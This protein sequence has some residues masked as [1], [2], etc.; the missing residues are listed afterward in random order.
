MRSLFLALALS[1]PATGL[2]AKVS[3][4]TPPAP[5]EGP[6][7]AR[8]ASS[9]S[10]YADMVPLPPVTGGD[11][12]LD[13]ERLARVITTFN[14]TVDASVI[15]EVDAEE[16]LGLRQHLAADPRWRVTL[17]DGAIQAF[18]RHETGQERAV[19]WHGF[20]DRRTSLVRVALRFE[21]WPQ[22]A[23]WATSDLVSRVSP[24]DDPM[25]VKAFVLGQP[26]TGWMAT[27]I[28]IEGSHLA[29]DIYDAQPTDDRSATVQT[30]MYKL[31]L[32][33]VLRD[34]AAVATER[35]FIPWQLPNGEPLQTGPP[36]EVNGMGPGMLEVRA[37]VNP[38]RPG[39]TWARILDDLVPWEAE[40]VGTG[41]LER[42]GWS[43]DPSHRFYF[44]SIFPVPRG[45]RFSG[46]V[47]IW[48][49]PDEGGPPERLEALPITIPRR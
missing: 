5:R 13:L 14:L 2:A 26:W 3:D 42:V 34:D 25:R 38:G 31:P 48:F 4:Q 23:A 24:S 9:A 47:E 37:R 18:E 40:A 43:A 20:R 19:P 21:P 45:K 27:A 32:V 49:Q 7:P 11:S 39:W 29:L 44:Q 22:T 16:A 30:L 10:P 6:A 46:T 15:G 1:L 36:A 33:G 8:P 41:T 35:G 17:W 28:S 12:R